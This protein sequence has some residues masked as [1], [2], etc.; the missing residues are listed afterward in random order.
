MRMFAALAGRSVRRHAALI[1][2]LGAGLS[3]F[4]FLLVAIARNLQREGLFSQLASLMPPFIQ[5]GFGGP[6]AASFGGTIALGFFHPVV[7]LALS[8]GAIFIASEPAGEIEA[9]L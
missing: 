7:M 2:A 5:E 9:G 4:Q 6:E 1:I 3:V 8:F